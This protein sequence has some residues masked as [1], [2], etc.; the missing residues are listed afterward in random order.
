MVICSPES[1]SIPADQRAIEPGVHYWLARK[2]STFFHATHWNNARAVKSDRDPTSFLSAEPRTDS[3]IITAGKFK[4]NWKWGSNSY[5][6]VSAVTQTRTQDF[7]LRESFNSIHGAINRENGRADYRCRRGSTIIAYKLH[8]PTSTASLLCGF[9][10]SVLIWDGNS[11]Y[12][13]PWSSGCC[14]ECPQHWMQHTRCSCNSA[15][16]QAHLCASN[17][18][19]SSLE[20]SHWTSP[21]PGT[22]ARSSECILPSLCSCLGAL[23]T[24]QFIMYAEI[25]RSTPRNFGLD[26]CWWLTLFRDGFLMR[27]YLFS[28]LMLRWMCRRYEI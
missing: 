8:T 23:S 3:L 5:Q 16:F 6:R 26:S 11:R 19:A 17:G 2:H 12:G 21:I 24:I 10:G 4:T 13:A 9:A 27:L 22:Q 25:F 1:A 14:I 15:T 7:A 20:A 28:W 18:L